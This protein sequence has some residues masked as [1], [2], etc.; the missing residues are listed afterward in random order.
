MGGKKSKSTSKGASNSNDNLALGKGLFIKA[1]C[2]YFF[3][4]NAFYIIKRVNRLI[5]LSLVIGIAILGL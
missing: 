3:S 1:F 4:N 5:Y 2:K